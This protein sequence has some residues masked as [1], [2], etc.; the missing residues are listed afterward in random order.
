MTNRK[1]YL[2]MIFL[3]ILSFALS[4]NLC[5]IDKKQTGFGNSHFLGG[6][7]GAWVMTTDEDFLDSLTDFSSSALYAD[8]FYAHRVAPFLSVEFSIGIFSQGDLEYDT[9]S[10]ITTSAVKLYPFFLSAK[11]YPLSKYENFALWPYL[12]LGGGIVHGTRDFTSIYYGDPANYYVEESQTKITYT[13]G[14]GIDWPIADQ[15]G[16]SVDY[17]NTPIKFGKHLAGLKEYSG[18]SLTFGIGYILKSK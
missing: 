14:F 2:P 13:W 11:L 6:H 7:F 9:E 15:I 3:L 18:W 1:R 10:G 12:R 17:R 5:A 4:S 8:F 16:L